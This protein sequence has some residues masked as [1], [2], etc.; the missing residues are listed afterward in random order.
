MKSKIISKYNTAIV[1]NWSDDELGFGQLTMSWNPELSRF[2]V[3][4]E[5][6]GIENTLKILKSIQL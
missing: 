5:H 4:S 2:V 6:L 3:D 1:V